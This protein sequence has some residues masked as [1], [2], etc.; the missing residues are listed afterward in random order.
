M[1]SE[2]QVPSLVLFLHEEVILLALKDKK[3]TV[4]A[5]TMYPYAIGGAVLAELL[6]SGRVRT[7]GEG[8]K[9]KIFVEDSSPLHDPL[10]DEWLGKIQ[11]SKRPRLIQEWVTKVAGTSKLKHRVAVQLCRRGILRT[12]EDKILGIFTRK[13]YPE[14]DPG[15]EREV[16]G[17]LEAAIFGDS[18]QVDPRTAVLVA[19]ASQAGILRTV[20]D[21]KLLKARKERLEGIADGSLAAE[22]TKGA[23][24]AMQAA[25]M[26][27][28]MVPIMT[29]STI[30]H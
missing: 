12:D 3:G 25:I 6:M 11:D 2:V 14:L 30:S 19:L 18:E 10:L 4:E 27:A 5:G 23:I 8:K 20:F 15:P 1:P 26:I 29:A 13:I 16:L 24:E 17:R 21:K 7:E 9:I 22:A 28:T